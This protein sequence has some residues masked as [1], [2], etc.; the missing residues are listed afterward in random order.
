MSRARILIS[1]TQIESVITP[2]EQDDPIL[3]DE[4]G[5]CRRR[6]IDSFHPVVS[7]PGQFARPAPVTDPQLRVTDDVM[8]VVVSVEGVTEE[9]LCTTRKFQL[10]CGTAT[11]KPSFNPEG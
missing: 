11:N 7:M 2:V 8:G 6:K 9:P 10:I 4:S 1:N 5:S 3:V